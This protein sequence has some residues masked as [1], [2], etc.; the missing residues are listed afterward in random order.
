MLYMNQL[1]YKDIIYMHNMQNGG[2]AEGRNNVATSGCGL[3]CACMMVDALTDKQLELTECVRLSE[4]NA[5][6]LMPGTDMTVLGPILA[7]K[8]GLTYSNTTSLDKAIAHLQNGGY[9]ISHV[10]HPAEGVPG[11][12]TFRGHYISL[13]STDGK[14][15]CILDPSYKEGK[16]DIP[17]REGKI[18][19]KNAPFLYCDVNILHGETKGHKY[20]LFARKK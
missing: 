7:E 13:I 8:F 17:E 2:P 1:K 4:D 12:F 6:N 14:E 20:H 16:F 18:N 10:G 11:L 19:E 5:A 3:C 15:F 9:I